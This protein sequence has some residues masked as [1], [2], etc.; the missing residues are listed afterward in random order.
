MPYISFGLICVLYGTGIYYLLPYS[1][2]TMNLS[3]VLGIFFV[4]LIGMILGLVLLAFNFQRLF[5][6]VITK[7]LFFWEKKSMKHLI[8]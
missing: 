2:L 5:E 1:L 7:I 4:I 6:I 3:L 8:I